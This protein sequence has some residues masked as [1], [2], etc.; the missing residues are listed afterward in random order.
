MFGGGGLLEGLGL[1]GSGAF[2][3]LGFQFRTFGSQVLGCSD[4]SCVVF[5]GFWVC[6]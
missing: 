1:K 4:V 2:E 6:T 3:G 5:F